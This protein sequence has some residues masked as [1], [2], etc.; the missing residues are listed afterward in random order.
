MPV[1]R[2]LSGI[3]ATVLLVAMCG[4]VAADPTV[5]IDADSLVK[6]IRENAERLRAGEFVATG[7]FTWRLFERDKTGRL[8]S[9]EPKEINLYQESI[10]CAFDFDKSYFS[11]RRERRPSE[12]ARKQPSLLFQYVGLPHHSVFLESQDDK[13]INVKV[14]EPGFPESDGRIFVQPVFDPRVIGFA[15]ILKLHGRFEDL[16][17]D[18]F[19]D[20]PTTVH[21]HGS[22]IWRLNRHSSVNSARGY[23]ITRSWWCDETQGLQPVKYSQQHVA[24]DAAPG[25]ARYNQQ[26][27]PSQESEV[28]WSQASGIWVPTHLKLFG[29]AYQ[30]DYRLQ[31]EI[32]WRNVN[33][34]VSEEVFDWRKWDLPLGTVVYDD[35]LH[36][37]APVMLSVIGSSLEVDL[38]PLHGDRKAFWPLIVANSAAVGAIMGYLAKKRLF[39]RSRRA[40]RNL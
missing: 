33:R 36:G 5:V 13:R 2:P 10:V 16:F 23:G 32:D 37:D 24:D 12:G 27:R 7:T 22:G 31:L 14:Q 38:P 1:P 39:N 19:P 6:T 17:K 20:E 8:T 40:V 11:F 25:A 18:Y 30:S 34:P 35:R 9:E 28:T 26:S 29:E 4:S 21:S 3:V 15:G